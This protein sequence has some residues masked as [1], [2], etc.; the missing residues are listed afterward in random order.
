MLLSIKANRLHAIK[1]NE[2]DGGCSRKLGG[3]LVPAV[4]DVVNTDSLCF[5]VSVCD[6]ETEVRGH[7]QISQWHH[8]HSLRIVH[9]Y[10]ANYIYCIYREIDI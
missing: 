9:F 1:D 7:V 6:T 4:V 3:H 8:N 2:G 10:Q 5:C